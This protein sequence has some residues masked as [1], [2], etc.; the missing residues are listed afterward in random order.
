MSSLT[1]LKTLLSTPVEKLASTGSSQPILACFLCSVL[2]NG[3]L[4]YTNPAPGPAVFVTTVG[5]LFPLWVVHQFLKVKKFNGGPEPLHPFP[6]WIWIPLLAVALVLRFDKLTALSTWPDMDEGMFGYFALRLSERWNWE[7]LHWVSQ[8]PILYTWGL[9]LTF[10]LL[11]PS[12]YSLWLFPALCSLL[13]LPLAWWALPKPIPASLLSLFLSL[14]AVSFWPAY[15]GRFSVQSVLLLPWELLALGLLLRAL[16]AKDGI[17][18]LGWVAALGAAAGAGFYIYLAWPLV[19]FV[20]GLVILTENSRLPLKRLPSAAVYAGV[21]SAVALPLLL[22]YTHENRGYFNHLGLYGFYHDL[23]GHLWLAWAYLKDLFWGNSAAAFRCGPVWGGLLNPVLTSLFLWGLVSLWPVRSRRWALW[24][25]GALLAFFTPALLTNDLEMMRLTPILPLLL[26]IAAYGG[27]WLFEAVPGRTRV[28]FLVLLLAVSGG[29]DCWHLLGAYDG[30]WL[31][32]PGYYGDHKSP[33]FYRAYSLLKPIGREE[34]PGLLLLDFNPDPYD[35]TL[36]VATYGM[37]AARNPQYKP[38]AALWGAVLANIHEQPYMS[39]LF[40]NGRWTWL[41][42]GINRDD[43][44]FLMDIIPLDAENRPKFEKWLR[45]DT[46]LRELTRLVMETDVD[47]HQ[48]A[49]LKVLEGAYPQFKGDPLLESR[50]WRIMALHHLAGGDSALALEDEKKAIQR[51]YPMAHL[52]NEMGGIYM[53]EKR[54]SEAKEAFESATKAKFN[55]TNAGD[56]LKLLEK[57]LPLD[58]HGH[59]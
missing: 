14:L 30:H 9:A 12:L 37:N 31:K 58:G 24:L 47:P 44:G 23:G 53:G 20:L 51:G 45:A 36:L 46:A 50:Y 10:K 7:L 11:G 35:Q 6:L 17:T 42:K 54:W 56:N 2:A 29:L 59:S 38:Q 26:G 18:R 13:C 21:T 40:P 5:V 43:G 1:K 28:P 33:E 16:L 52:Y 15:I 3:L 55:L 39:K 4:S 8:E 34:G 49:M 27:L 57:L 41:S 22:A 19:A 25:V 48:G 32:N